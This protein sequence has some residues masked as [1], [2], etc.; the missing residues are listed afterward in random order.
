MCVTFHIQC[1]Q[2]SQIKYYV[3][4]VFNKGKQMH[5]YKP[6]KTVKLGTDYAD[7]GRNR[8]HLLVRFST[9]LN[10]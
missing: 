5:V 3:R 7:N 6:V 10:L 2:I 1:T 9:H 4:H 8:V